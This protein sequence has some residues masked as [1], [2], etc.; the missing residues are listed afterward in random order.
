MTDNPEINKLKLRLAREKNARKQAEQLLEEKSLALF[1]SNKELK[2]LTQHLESLVEERTRALQCSMQE[3]LQ[4][5]TAKSQFLTNISHE[6]KTPLNGILGSLNLLKQTALT[7][8]Q[9]YMADTAENCGEKLVQLINN[10]LDVSQLSNG[11]VTLL[12]VP[13]SATELTNQV[14]QELQSDIESKALTVSVQVQ[15]LPVLLRGDPQR[16]K[17]L[18]TH[19]LSNAIKFS[20][21]GKIELILSYSQAGFTLVVTDQGIGISEQQQK[22]IFNLFTQ[23]DESLTRLHGGVGLG[24]TLC[25]KICHLFGGTIT[26]QSTLNQGTK[27]SVTLPLAQDSEEMQQHAQVLASMAG[28]TEQTESQI[29]F[30]GQT[31]LLVED[32]IINQQVIS[33]LLRAMNVEVIIAENGK[34]GVDLFL[35][36]TPHLILMDIQM[37]VMDGLEAMRT[38]RQSGRPNATLPILA[39]TAHSLAEDLK[40]SFEA[41]A[42]EHLTKPINSATLAKALASYLAHDI[43]MTHH[44]KTIQSDLSQEVEE[45]YGIDLPGVTERLMQNEDL[46]AK[47][48]AMFVEQYRGFVEPLQTAIAALDHETVQRALHTLKGSAGNISALKVAEYSAALEKSLK[49]ATL[50]NAWQEQQQDKLT[51]LFCELDK[52]IKALRN[53]LNLDEKAQSDGSPQGI[54]D[55]NKTQV[56]I[57]NIVQ[58]IYVDLS[59]V[60]SG[61]KQLQS[62]PMHPALSSHVQTL[63][64]AL[65]NFDY[66]EMEQSCSDMLAILHEVPK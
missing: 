56:C 49:N 58:H 52:V 27:V 15:Q 32:N 19:L 65:Q 13:F 2:D 5:A 3:A 41:G 57:E 61:L 62:M 47:V 20:Q 8:E 1:N 16:I 64:N 34:K 9:L 50:S 26:L 44:E 25:Q 21:N 29:R 55:A 42:D 10:V 51:D 30:Q 6:L 33:D 38:I 31:V 17:Q 22:D 7:E 40:R 23:A 11:K 60:E 39:L 63:Q 18:L 35:N 36:S 24:L 4:L 28:S 45:L 37:P 54:F 14:L 12:N 48:F 43:G 53:R 66:D 59:E 46:V